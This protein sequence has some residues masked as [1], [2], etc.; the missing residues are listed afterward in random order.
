M[1]RGRGQDDWLLV[2]MEVLYTVCLWIIIIIEWF[3][4]SGFRQAILV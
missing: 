2:S 4:S 3:Y 1:H